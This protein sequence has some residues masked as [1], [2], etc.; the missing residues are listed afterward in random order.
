MKFR[1]NWPSRSREKAVTERTDRQR[2]EDR[3]QRSDRGL[4][5]N[6]EYTRSLES[7]GNQKDYPYICSE[8]IQR[9][10]SQGICD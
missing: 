10:T 5:D 2:T 3:G 6:D 1:K 9:E 7:Q 4:T 8:I